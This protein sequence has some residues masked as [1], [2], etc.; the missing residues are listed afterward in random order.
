MS[1]AF[2]AVAYRPG[3]CTV[4]AAPVRGRAVVAS[5]AADALARLEPGDVL[6]VQTTSAPY[7]TVFPIVSAVAVEQ[8]SAMGHAAVLARE[9]GLTA[10]IGLP[11]LL[12]RVRDGDLVEV[13]PGAGTV[14]VLD[15]GA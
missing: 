12:A 14:S 1:G 10:V 9:L 4:G 3:T 15:R 11:G 2:T 6:V 5:D 13:D 8:G 7:N